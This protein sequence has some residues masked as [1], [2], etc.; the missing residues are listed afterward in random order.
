MSRQR[1]LA[2][3]RREFCDQH[4]AWQHRQCHVLG[5][6]VDAPQLVDDLELQSVLDQTFRV[7]LRQA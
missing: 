1:G 4:A 7:V 2:A 5:H 6:A 3:L